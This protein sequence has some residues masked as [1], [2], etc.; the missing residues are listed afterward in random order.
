MSAVERLEVSMNK[1]KS[2]ILAIWPS[3]PRRAKYLYGSIRCHLS[4]EL[5]NLVT[6][7]TQVTQKD[8]RYRL[9]VYIDNRTDMSL[10]GDRKVEELRS[11]EKRPLDKGEQ[12]E[13]ESE[14]KKSKSI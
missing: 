1:G 8:G 7:V 2:V 10:L 4:R 12:Y 13:K 9:D 6:R 11:V 3:F 5:F 14:S